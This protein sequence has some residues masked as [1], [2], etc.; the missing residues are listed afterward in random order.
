[1]TPNY[2]G[3]LYVAEYFSFL[4]CLSIYFLE[5]EISFYFYYKNVKMMTVYY[6]TAIGNS[7][8]NKSNTCGDEIRSIKKLLLKRRACPIP[9]S[10]ILPPIHSGRKVKHP[11][12][13]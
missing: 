9:T 13:S 1:M 6:C 2:F 3:F 12:V 8:H 5:C 11:I 4:F 10:D 7:N